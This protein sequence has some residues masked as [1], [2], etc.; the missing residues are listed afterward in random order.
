MNIATTYKNDID[1]YTWNN[2]IYVIKQC[3]TEIHKTFMYIP[4]TLYKTFYGYHCLSKHEI[5]KFYDVLFEVIYENY[6]QNIKKNSNIISQ[7]GFYF[8]PKRDYLYNQIGLHDNSFKINIINSFQM[9]DYHSTSKID[10]CVKTHPLKYK[11]VNIY[12]I[13]DNSKYDIF[14]YCAKKYYFPYVIYQ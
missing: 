1:S 2:N 11:I 8:Y 4:Y 5:M 7:H 6:F 13:N 10:E 12:N 14:N 9:I 3:T